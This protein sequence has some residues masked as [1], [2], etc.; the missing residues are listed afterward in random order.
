[1]RL[2]FVGGSIVF[3]GRNSRPKSRGCKRK[4]SGP[5]AM[6]AHFLYKYVRDKR[7]GI[8][9]LIVDVSLEG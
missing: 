1:M 5:L 8:V 2:S 7:Y 6:L 3:S 4:K 9:Y